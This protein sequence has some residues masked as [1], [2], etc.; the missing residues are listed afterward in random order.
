MS[1]RAWAVYDREAEECH[2]ALPLREQYNWRPYTLRVDSRACGRVPLG[3][4][5]LL[6][7]VRRVLES[8]EVVIQGWWPDSRRVTDVDEQETRTLRPQQPS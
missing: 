1:W 7:S 2:R 8:Y 6:V 3:R 5:L 4:A